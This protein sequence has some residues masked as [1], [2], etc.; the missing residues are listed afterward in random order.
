MQYQICL[1]WIINLKKNPQQT[2]VIIF[3]LMFSDLCKIKNVYGLF[4]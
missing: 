4:G 3:K 2:R 1:N